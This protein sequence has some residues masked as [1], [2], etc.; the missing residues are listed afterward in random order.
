MV[1]FAALPPE[2]NS[3]RLFAG[4]GPEEMLKTAAAYAAIAEGF[5]TA[6]AASDG[7]MGQMEVIWKGPS[8]DT[9]QGAFRNHANWLRTEGDAAAAT[10]AIAAGVAAANATAL[11]TMPT[12]AEIETIQ[13]AIVAASALSS[14]SLGVG[15][16]TVAALEGLYMAEWARAVVVMTTYAGA[17]NALMAQLPPPSQAPPIVSG[18]PPGAPP[19]GPGPGP[20]TPGHDPGGGP[21]YT[22]DTGGGDTGSQPPGGSSDGP[23]QPGQPG[24]PGQP[25]GDPGGDPGNP[26]QPGGDPGQPGGEQPGQPTVPQAQQPIS[27][28]PTMP[29][30]GYGGGDASLS[31]NGGLLGASPNSSTLAGLNGGLGSMVALGMT[32]SG[33]G[34]MSG[35]ASGLRMP[36][37]WSSMPTRAFGMGTGKPVAQPIAPRT[38]PRGV[39]APRVRRRRD[40]DERKPSKAFA[41]GESQDVPVLEEPPAIGVIEYLDGDQQQESISEQL[42]AIDINEGRGDDDEAT[43]DYLAPIPPR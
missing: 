40:R 28:L 22:T 9:A 43:L 15:A 6:A 16:V 33:F 11:A 39:S 8:A 4:P 37:N 24:D 25:G 17:T 26:G 18:G 41:P 23:G 12:V 21:T 7:S 42:L 1:D 36:T 38:A 32:P 19:G 14:S 20:F 29:T 31:S 3:A 35:S 2:V 13:A 30:D 10:S 27:E 34:A 5:H